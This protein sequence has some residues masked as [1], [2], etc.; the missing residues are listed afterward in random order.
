M[1]KTKKG[2]WEAG[3]HRASEGKEGMGLR[4]EG[5]GQTAQGFAGNLGNRWGVQ[6][7]ECQ[8]PPVYFMKPS[9]AAL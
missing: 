2:E 6:S 8:G 9:L 5:G 4:S 3:A 1:F 7:K